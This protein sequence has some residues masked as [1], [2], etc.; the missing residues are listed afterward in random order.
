MADPR[1]GP[2]LIDTSI[3]IRADQKGHQPLKESVQRLLTAGLAVICWPIRAELL[4]GVKTPERWATLDE[5]LAA[6]GHVPVTDE[7]WF[8]ASRLGN[9]LARKGE[10]VPL[11]DLLIAVA[12]IHARLPLWTTDSDFKRIAQ[13]APLELDWV[14]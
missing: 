5:Q 6:L 11:A 12:A 1:K 13:Y 4:I 8:H 3:W 14:Q 2:R 9:K 10:T 7:T